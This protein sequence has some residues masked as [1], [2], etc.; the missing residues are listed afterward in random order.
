MKIRI[1]MENS[2]EEFDLFCRIR[3]GIMRLKNWMELQWYK[4]DIEVD[5]TENGLT[6]LCDSKYEGM[7]LSII[8]AAKEGAYEMI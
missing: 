7:I 2:K 3:T 6:I 5:E 4:N 1:E 8:E